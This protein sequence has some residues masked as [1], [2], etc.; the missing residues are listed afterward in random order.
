MQ[1]PFLAMAFWSLG[2]A[3]VTPAALA[4]SRAPQIP[5]VVGKPAYEELVRTMREDELLTVSLLRFIDSEPH[6]YN[7][8]CLANLK[9][10]RL[11][12]TIA[13]AMEPSISDEEVAEGL[14]FYKTEAGRKFTE[15]VYRQVVENEPLDDDPTML[16]KYF[17][18]D[19]LR[20]LG[21]FGKS[22]LGAKLMGK[23][24][25]MKQR[26]VGLSVK[27]EVLDLLN[28][29]TETLAGMRTLVR[30][31]SAPIPNPEG[32][33][34]ARYKVT[35][36]PK[37][38]VQSTSISTTC[39]DPQM[40]ARGHNAS[41]DGVHETVGLRWT[42]ARTLEVT[43]PPGVKPRYRSDEGRPGNEAMKFSFR[44]R[45]PTDPPATSCVAAPPLDEFG[46]PA[47]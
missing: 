10:S 27:A 14:R 7:P 30:C 13:W 46:W 21:R 11:T 34:S 12:T 25:V 35:S 16:L 22:P 38:N 6:S 31:E 5:V 15:R 29:C 3:A 39:T 20:E 37:P 8:K 17:S 40:S 44:A 45:K 26:R 41:L 32:N 4:Q 47:G 28:I 43:L 2:L 1:H 24:G 19:E 36:V 18:V 23:E 9:G 42:D 33:C